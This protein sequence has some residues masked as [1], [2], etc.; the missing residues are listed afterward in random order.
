MWCSKISAIQGM[1]VLRFG[2]KVCSSGSRKFRFLAVED[3][4]Y[5]SDLIITSCL[6]AILLYSLLLIDKGHRP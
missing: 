4:E 1:C 5:D 3:A 6:V 2:V